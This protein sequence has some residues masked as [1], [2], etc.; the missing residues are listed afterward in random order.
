MHA[1]LLLGSNRP[2]AYDVSSPNSAITEVTPDLSLAK[3]CLT[4]VT[5]TPPKGFYFNPRFEPTLRMAQPESD[6]ETYALTP[7]LSHT[8]FFLASHL[9]ICEKINVDGGGDKK[10][11]SL[12]YGT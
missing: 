12:F 7:W 8:I 1:H 3:S 6:A 11:D 9:I 5:A 10:L 4:S 2:H